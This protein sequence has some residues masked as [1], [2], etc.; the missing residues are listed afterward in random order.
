MRASAPQKVSRVFTGIEAVLLAI[1]VPL[2]EE[3]PAIPVSLED[4]GVQI[5][6]KKEKIEEILGA[7]EN[8]LTFFSL[9]LLPLDMG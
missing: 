8:D 6:T 2:L 1:I 9:D 5:L 4:D 7:V 3:K